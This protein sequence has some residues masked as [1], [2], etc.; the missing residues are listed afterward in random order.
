MKTNRVWFT[1]DTHFFSYG[2][3]RRRGMDV[4]V[5]NRA[6][7]RSWN[8]VVSEGDFVYHL[9]DVLD[10][11]QVSRSRA[12]ELLDSLNGSVYIV[13]GNHDWD[14]ISFL[15]SLPKTLKVFTALLARINESVDV[16]MSHYPHVSWRGSSNGTI[17]L[18][19][20]CHGT[21]PPGLSKRLDAGWDVWRR[22]IS[23][24]EVVD[25]VRFKPNVGIDGL[26]FNRQSDRTG[27]VL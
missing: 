27:E 11:S 6:I 23:L 17:H 12:V 26:P 13:A 14:V 8:R 2:T 4:S 24:E 3:A 20:H 21:L 9:G 22:P 7:A 16:Y 18:H 25:A 19:G 5:M 15:G 1:A 10:L